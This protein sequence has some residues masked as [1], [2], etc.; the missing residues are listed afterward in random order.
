M[1]IRCSKCQHVGPPAE[2]RPR[3]DGVELVCQNCG[4]VNTI[5]TG[6]LPVVGDAGGS[7]AAAAVER[8]VPAESAREL[9][10][11]SRLE[12]LVP[13]PGD[14]PRCRKCAHL[15]EP[16]AEACSRCGLNVA[17]GEKY[18]PGEA[19][20]E[21]PPEGKEDVFEQA[22]LLWKSVL[23]N[24]TDDNLLK[25]T[26][27]AREERLLE[28]G[29]RQVRFFLVDHPDDEV[30]LEELREMGESF[31][32]QA[33][34]AQAHAAVRAENSQQPGRARQILMWLTLVVWSGLLVVFLA[35][36]WNSCH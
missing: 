4:H 29:V 28:Y 22:T 24:P 27:F 10:E 25:F 31:Q 33:I 14:G 1:D 17:E 21:R 5:E 11:L 35:L 23:E 2:I 12:K 36:Q 30:A 34:V 7:V 3:D 15:L 26:A 13:V 20:W 8:M 16:D 6:G 9:A 32:A 19:P 18:G